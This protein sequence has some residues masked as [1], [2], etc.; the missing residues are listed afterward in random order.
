MEK[1]N[2]LRRLANL[3]ILLPRTEELIEQVTT[4]PYI[5][6]STELSN[7]FFLSFITLTIGCALYRKITPDFKHLKTVG[8]QLGGNKITFGNH[9]G[10]KGH[11]ILQQKE[12]LL[13]YKM[14]LERE[15]KDMKQQ[16]V[17]RVWKNKR[18]IIIRKMEMW[19]YFPAEPRRQIFR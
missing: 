9:T 6:F 14:T 1:R 19:Y 8:A 7:I 5:F 18:F 10:R 3:K 11:L 2:P 16:R 4:V 15:Q 17:N 12:E 13:K